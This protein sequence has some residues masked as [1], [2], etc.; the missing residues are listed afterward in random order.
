MIKSYAL[1]LIISSS[2]PISG[3][4]IILFI[5]FSN[6]L[7]ILLSLNGGI[8]TKNSYAITPN[9]HQSIEKFDIDYPLITSG[10]I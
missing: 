2:S 8:P 4:S 3:H 7:G 9:A 5:I 6:T 10:G 1:K